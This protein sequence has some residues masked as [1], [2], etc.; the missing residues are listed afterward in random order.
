MAPVAGED[1]AQTVKLDPRW[2]EDAVSRAEAEADRV[3]RLAATLGTAC[4]EG[5]DAVVRA[6]AG[7]V[8]EQAILDNAIAAGIK[9][10]HNARAGL[11]ADNEADHDVVARVVRGAH[12]WLRESGL[13][14]DRR[15]DTRVVS[16]TYQCVNTVRAPPTSCSPSCVRPGTRA[17]WMRSPQTPQRAG[18][19]CL[20]SRRPMRCTTTT[21]CNL[22]R[23]CVRVWARGGGRDQASDC[24]LALLSNAGV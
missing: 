5:I 11:E 4:H 14:L 3:K 19:L 23:A 9:A 7:S 18:A 24:V 2:L 16:H 10:L 6:D 12:G 8:A 17:H 22:Q 21:R 1:G 20:T 13:N 15:G